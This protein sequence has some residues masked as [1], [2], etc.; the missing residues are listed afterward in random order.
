MTQ[1]KKLDR[2]SV[3]EVM[4]PGGYSEI[5]LSNK[6]IFN[7]KNDKFLR[8]MSEES[9]VRPDKSD[10]VEIVE[11]YPITRAQFASI[12]EPNLWQYIALAWPFHESNPKNDGSSK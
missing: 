6:M 11:L 12:I 10:P 7:V 8:W 1:I 2:E 4:Q 5:L 9:K 3:L